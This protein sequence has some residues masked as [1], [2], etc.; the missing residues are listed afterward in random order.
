MGLT[1]RTIRD[2]WLAEGREF[3]VPAR[4][5]KETLRDTLVD[6][7]AYR[8]AAKV[9]VRRAMQR[10]IEGE[11]EPEAAERKRSR[12]RGSQGYS[13]VF[14]DPDGQR[15]GEGSGQLP[16]AESD[17]LKVKYQR[18]NKLEAIAEAKPRKWIPLRRTSGRRRGGAFHCFDGEVLQ[19]DTNAAQ[20][21]LS[22]LYDQEI[23]LHTPHWK[24]KEI[25]LQRTEQFLAD[26]PQR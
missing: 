25:L 19:A 24:V 8:E 7:T 4:L 1:Y 13:E 10:R 9:E 16:G 3:D 6:V 22:R 14:I 26:T 2:R 15:Y 17:T 23:Q 21:V 11:E 5:W 20:G 18:R 12:V